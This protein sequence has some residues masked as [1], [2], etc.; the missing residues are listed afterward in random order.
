MVSRGVLEN[1]YLRSLDIETSADGT[2]ES[3]AVLSA[4]LSTITELIP[5]ET[6]PAEN[7]EFF[8]IRKFCQSA[9]SV[10][11]AYLRLNASCGGVADSGE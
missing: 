2:G 5:G 8:V 3:L 4:Q 9:N 7:F 10:V 1:I 6:D 11:D